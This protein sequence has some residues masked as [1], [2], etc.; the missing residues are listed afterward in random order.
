MNRSNPTVNDTTRVTSGYNYIFIS[1]NIHWSVRNWRARPVYSPE[2]TLAEAHKGSQLAQKASV[3]TSRFP[4][5][6]MHSKTVHAAA[7]IEIYLNNSVQM[8]QNKQK[9][10]VI[11][12]CF[13]DNG[14]HEYYV[15]PMNIIYKCTSHK[16]FHSLFAN[17]RFTQMLNICNKFFIDLVAFILEEKP[18]IWQPFGTQLWLKQL[19]NSFTL[20]IDIVAH[21]K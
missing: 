10:A 9:W 7:L 1:G 21:S 20:P 19:C 14:S 18:S 12:P 3:S 4:S 6:Q 8:H 13:T 15:K 2:H 11:N 17:K 16:F 5:T